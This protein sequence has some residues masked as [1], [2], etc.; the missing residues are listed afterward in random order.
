MP[1][2][3]TPEDR[4]RMLMGVDFGVSRNPSAREYEELGRDPFATVPEEV[5]L[6]PMYAAGPVY[7]GLQDPPP[8]QSMIPEEWDEGVSFSPP[9][10]RERTAAALQKRRGR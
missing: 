4:I 9:S 10:L 6:P 7:M 8:L 2:S 3:L 1:N 5:K